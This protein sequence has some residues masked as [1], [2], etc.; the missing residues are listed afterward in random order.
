M[1]T[2]PDWLSS[3]LQGFF[4]LLSTGWQA[5]LSHGCWV[6]NSGPPVCSKCTYLTEPSPHPSIHL[7]N[8]PIQTSTESLHPTFYPLN[9]HLFIPSSPHIP[10]TATTPLCSPARTFEPV[11]CSLPAPCGSGQDIQPWLAMTFKFTGALPERTPPKASGWPGHRPHPPVPL[12]Q[13]LPLLAPS[14]LAIPATR[15]HPR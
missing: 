1:L 4:C 13:R 8:F 15:S 14:F 7:V 2:H 3:E 6:S 5:H 10:F 11:L 12:T 9:P